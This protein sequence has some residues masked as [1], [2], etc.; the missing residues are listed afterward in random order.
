[1]VDATAL[2]NLGEI[3]SDQGRLDEAREIFDEALGVCR[4]IHFPV[5]HALCVSNLGRVASRAGRY[6]DARNWFDE[7]R[8]RFRRIGADSFVVEVDSREAE[9]RLFA[10][11]AEG[12]VELAD[13]AVRRATSLGGI[14]VAQSML[15]R[16][17]GVA[18]MLAGHDDPARA[19][20]EASRVR[21]ID[22]AADYELALTLHAIAAVGGGPGQEATS[23]AAASILDRLGVVDIE[24]VSAVRVLRVV[25]L[26]NPRVAVD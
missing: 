23:I 9:R 14:P 20:L 1:M 3:L 13:D 4:S 24:A 18:L 26:P 8:D 16:I 5:G 11:D 12:A 25:R 6:D 15:D 19:R 21:A 22:A 2:N 10:G 17:A 7:A